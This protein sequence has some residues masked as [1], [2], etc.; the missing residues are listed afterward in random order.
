MASTSS[1]EGHSEEMEC[2][3]PFEDCPQSQRIKE[4]L[5]EYQKIIQQ[6]TAETAN[7]SISHSNDKRLCNIFNDDYTAVQLLD[8]FQ[9]L[10]DDHQIEEDPDRF[11][12]FLHFMRDVEPEIRCSARDCEILRRHYRR[13]SDEKDKCDDFR[14]SILCQIHSYLI[15]SMDTIKLTKKERV[16]LEAKLNDIDED[17]EANATLEVVRQKTAEFEEIIGDVATSKFI[18]EIDDENA[19][20]DDEQKYPENDEG[21]NDQLV[22]EM[23]DEAKLKTFCCITNI[24]KENAALFL[25]DSKWNLSDSIDK[26]YA[27]GGDV[28]Q[29]ESF[30]QFQNM[31]YVQESNTEDVVYTEGVRLWYWDRAQM[32]SGALAVQPKHH[33]LKAEIIEEIGISQWNR[34]WQDCENRMLTER[35]RRLQASGNGAEQYGILAGALFTI[36]HL[37]SLKLYTDFNTLN[38]KFCSFFRLKKVVGNLLESAKSLAVRNGTFRHWA[39]LLIECVQC[40][41]TMLVT[42]GKKKRY[43]R[44]VNKAFIFPRF[45]T[46]FHVPL[47]TSKNVC[48]TDLDI[49]VVFSFVFCVWFVGLMLFCNSLTW[50]VE[51]MTASHC[52][53][54]LAVPSP[55][56]PPPPPPPLSIPLDEVSTSTSFSASTLVSFNVPF[57]VTSSFDISSDSI[58]STSICSESN[59]FN[60]SVHSLSALSSSE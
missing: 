41:G 7:L 44:G 43:Y 32:P 24:D 31:T 26:F 28:T 1:L 35:V 22:S 23:D 15:H 60:D 6:Q 5:F 2:K 4:V 36:F 30:A 21:P 50:M 12:L 27:F 14:I 39:K 20:S 38:A 16:Q 29:L 40:F 52:F 49:D 37:M 58:S 10:I 11:D 47:S 17:E 59:V 25:Q 57:E 53:I 55:S 48:N 33:D 42:R 8:D 54:A 46:R 34:L 3:Y 9:H 51:N 18:S 19:E 13:R 45:I 56:A